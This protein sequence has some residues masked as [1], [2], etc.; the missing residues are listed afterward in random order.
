M[1]QITI[2]SASIGNGHNEASRALKEQLELQGDNVQIIDTFQSIH[3]LLHK[4]FLELY[5]KMIEKTPRLWGRLYRYSEEFSWFL[6]MDQLGT[7]F[8]QKLNSILK[9]QSTTIMISTH[10]FVTAFLSRLKKKKNINIPLYTVITDLYLHPAYVR[11]EIDG[12]FTASPYIEEF[13]KEYNVPIDQLFCTGIPI[14]SIPDVNIPRWKVR[15]DLKLQSDEK[16][17]LITG[18]GLGLGKYEDLLETLEQLE[19]KV[20]VLCMTGFNSEL[21]KRIMA[22]NSKHRIHVISYTERFT[23]YLRAS[24]VVLSKAGGLTMAE[25]LACETPTVIY[26]PVPG[27]EEDNAQFLIDFGAAVK[28]E[29]IGDVKNLVEKML[30]DKEYYQT[31]VNNA[32]K[33]KK[34]EAAKQIA[35]MIKQLETKE[36]IL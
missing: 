25:A 4:T 2:F 30:E 36:Q 8:C 26:Q 32:K 7:F 24:D 20:Q 17:I 10:P 3:P 35:F 18:G 21:E 31:L 14:K 13:S 16:T 27:H 23:E 15:N 6:L 28:A 11:P 1:S 33:I 9:K 12:Y 22:L 29:K 5:L 19:E 34:P